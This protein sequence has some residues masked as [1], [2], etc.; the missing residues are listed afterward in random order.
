[1]LGFSWTDVA[2]SLGG[3]T[4]WGASTVVLFST[5]SKVKVVRNLVK[6]NVLDPF[7][8]KVEKVLHP[9]HVKIDRTERRVNELAEALDYQFRPNGGNSLR[10]RVDAGVE[11]AGGPPPP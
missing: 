11:A 7:W 4:L 9:L 8:E 1:M 3:L 5:L 6:R 2:E 10:D